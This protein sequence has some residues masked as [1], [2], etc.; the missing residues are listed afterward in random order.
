MLHDDIAQHGLSSAE[1]AERLKVE[2]YNELPQQGHRGT[3]QIVLGVLR[4]PMFALLLAAGVIY[5]LLGDLT[6]ALVL[7]GFATLS[8]SIAV[9]QESRSERVLEA[10]RNLS[11]PRAL[12]VRDGVQMRIPGREVVRGDVMILSEGDRVSADARLIHARDML[13]DESLLTGESV[14]V[15]KTSGDAT[16]EMRPGGDG[17]PLVYSGSLVVRG[18]GTGIVEATGPKSE[19]GRIGVSLGE[20]QL[21]PPRLQRETARI[22]RIFGGVAAV[23]CVAVV[24]LQGLVEGAWLPAFLSGIAVGMSMLPEEFPLV[25]TVFM[26]MGAWRISRARVLTRRAAAIESLGAATV[27]C[28]DKTGT[29]TQNRMTLAIVETPSTRWQPESDD[30]P[31]D[32]AEVLRAALLSSA[33]E[34]IEPMERAVHETAERLEGG[35]AGVHAGR[36]RVQEY[37]LRPDLLAVTHVWQS[38]ADESRSVYA[39]GAPEAIAGLCAMPREKLAWLHE[40]VARIAE[41]GVRVLGVARGDATGASLPES[42][43]GF[44]FEFLGLVGFMDPLRPSVPDAVRECQSAG[45][46]V[47]MLTGDYPVTARAIAAQAGIETPYVLSGP[48]VAAMPDA[49]LATALKT[50]NVFAR[51]MPEQ[52]LKIVQALKADGEIV[53]MTGDGV[54]DAP[55]LKASHIGI[56]MGGRGTDV[57]REAASIVLLDDDFTS[58]VRTVRLGRRIYD[59]LRKAMGYIVAVHIPIAGLALLPLLFGLPPILTPIHIAFLEMVI[60]PACSIVFESEPEERNVMRRPPRRPDAP[61][62]SRALIV[63]GLVQGVLLLAAVA[64]TMGIGLQRAMPENELRALTFT[65]MVLVNVGAILVDGS[66]ALSLRETVLRASRVFWLLLAGITAALS[67]ALFVPQGRA[68]FHFGPLHADDLGVVL[69]AGLASLAAIVL[70]KP[71]FRARMS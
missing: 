48:E 42:P 43:R 69:L 21:E 54:N 45:I 41:E 7:L 14:P 6:E 35:R 5:L 56:A 50:V 22:V 70:L 28:T 30:V 47:V 26:V 52:K 9:V 40:T 46:R 55:A 8:T 20:L 34:A 1:A 68:L 15:S 3:V 71:I 10:L 65:A 29:L 16:A 31:G 66:Y 64:V 18:R 23:V 36:T 49:D 58:I 4:E 12:V 19:I 63:W 2:G 57:A 25:L 59:N 24:L 38:D 39:K 37:G 17:Q 60:D 53:A 27:L 44:R 67:F 61:I 32:I 11:S 51:I 62:L 13:A 33:G